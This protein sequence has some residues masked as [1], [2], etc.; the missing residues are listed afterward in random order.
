[1]IRLAAA[2]LAAG[3]TGAGPS[4]A[5]PPG[6]YHGVVVWAEGTGTRVQPVAFTPRWERRAAGADSI[7]AFSRAPMADGWGASGRLRG[8]TLTWTLSRL[9][10]DVGVSFAFQGVAGPDG[11]VSGCAR[12]GRPASLSQVRAAFALAP[13]DRPAPDAADAPLAQCA[14]SEV[15]PN[16]DVQS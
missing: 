7:L 4:P 2:L 5:P 1:M 9:V 6:G 13:A 10:G 8:D 14:P 3:C 15:T 16:S 11:R 12:P